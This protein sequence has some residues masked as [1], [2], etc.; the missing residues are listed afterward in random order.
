VG[1]ISWKNLRFSSG[2][3]ANKT[4]PER[5]AATAFRGA[6]S[7]KPP[8]VGMLVTT[9]QIAFL[10]LLHFQGKFNDLPSILVSLRL[11]ELKKFFVQI[12]VK[13]TIL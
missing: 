12:L 3:H 6:V 2:G 7:I 10:P 1:R 11:R 8:G 9:S 13:R 5:A 4:L